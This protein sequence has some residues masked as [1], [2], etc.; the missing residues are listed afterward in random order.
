MI[1]K[2]TGKGRVNFQ[3]VLIFSF[4]LRLI[5]VHIQ[6]IKMKRFN[7]EEQIA[8]YLLMYLKIVIVAYLIRFEPIRS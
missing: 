5:V 7:H 6:K 8:Y 1:V 4:N 2:Q 3:M